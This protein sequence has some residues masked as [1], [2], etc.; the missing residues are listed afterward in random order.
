MTMNVLIDGDSVP[1]DRDVFVELLEN[2]VASEYVDYE[3]ALD[4][5]SISFKKLEKL[6]RRGEI[7][8]S[9]FFA[10]IDLV[11]AQVATKTST[12]L[13]GISKDTFSVNT[14]ETV[15]LRRIELIVKDLL[16][17][18]ALLKK[19]DTTL[20]QNRI[21]GLLGRPGTTV[22]DDAAKLMET[23]GLTHADLLA[24]RNKEAALELLIERLGANQILVARS[25]QNYMPQRLKVKFSGMAI[26]D[27]KVPY[28]FLANEPKQE[29]LHG[30]N[31]FTLTLL[32]VLIAHGKFMSVKYNSTVAGTAPGR[33]YQ[34]VEQ[35]LMP[36]DEMR[37]LPLSG[38]DEI[39]T[40]S[41]RLKVTPS[42]VTVRA[43]HLKLIDFETAEAHL[44]ELRQRHANRPK[45]QARS[46]LPVNA[47]KKYAGRE[48]VSRMLD[49][50]DAGK[51]PPAQF[52]RAVCFGKLKP[53]QLGELRVA[54]G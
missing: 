33:E 27:K 44:A 53:A 9:L 22:E 32:T 10:P 19:H 36:A 37:R 50:V 11:R 47:V 17:K 24:T 29:E 20:T 13:E 6:A 12:L 21:V 28:I 23:I 14:R 48:L 38:L 39:E 40:A 2:S 54:V 7:P 15:E 30:R 35:I 5:D 31:V 3:H 46:P 16:R 43:L 34:I 18:Q 42:A 1:I 49:A 26:K 51:V 45:S 52:C 4:R 8:Y 41:A 25:V